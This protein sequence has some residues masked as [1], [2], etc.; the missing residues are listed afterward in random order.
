MKDPHKDIKMQ[1]NKAQ[2]VI[3]MLHHRLVSLLNSYFTA[4]RWK[5]NTHSDLLVCKCHAQQ[6]VLI[7]RPTKISLFIE[8]DETPKLQEFEVM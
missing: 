7:Y 8:L 6:N 2:V 1:N 4:N 5:T 3:L